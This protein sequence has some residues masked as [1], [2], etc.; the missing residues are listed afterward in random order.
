M[1][2][3]VIWIMTV[4]L[5]C[6]RVTRG[7][8][9]NLN[10]TDIER[11]RFSGAAGPASQS[12]YVFEVEQM[13]REKGFTLVELLVVITVIGI[14]VALAVPNMNKL[15]TKAKEAKVMNGG[16]VIQ[17]A[18]ET[19]ASSHNGLYPG[20]AVPTCENL[21]AGMDGTDPFFTGGYYTM[22]ALI[23]GGRVKPQDPNLD[24]LDGFYFNL[25]PAWPTPYQIPDRLVGDGVLDIY[26]EN[27]FRTNIRGVTD[28]AVPMV[29]IFGIEFVR[30]PVTLFDPDNP[31]QVFADDPAPVRLCEPMWFGA[32]ND[33]TTLT[34]P[35]IY[36]F[37]VPGGPDVKFMGDINNLL[38]YDRNDLPVDWK[39]T[40]AEIQQ[41]GFP[42]GNFAYIPLDPVQPD[43]T[44]PDFMRYCRN[45]WLVLYG[46]TDTAQ[47]NKYQGVLPSF[48][49]PLGDGIPN[50]NP[51]TFDVDSTAYEWTVKQ[52]L[53]GAMDVLATAY[54][55][56]LRVEGS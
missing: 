49:R 23:G 29:N 28:Q 27:P 43:P 7:L 35:G 3:F 31:W 20:L 10:K 33:Y 32:D 17:T 16:H 9:K 15:K 1:P 4:C 54:E 38:R 22:R 40:K 14:L 21:A 42:E 37:P 19:F 11:E 46:G 48:P 30:D 24:F 34:D 47:R 44:Q 8:K 45:Y 51:A 12:H 50:T 13:N 5:T 53:V 25:D 56:Q 55:D 36:D 2:T 18:L 52:A 39:V 41:S 6:T 26:P